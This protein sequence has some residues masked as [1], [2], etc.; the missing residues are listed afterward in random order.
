[1][2]LAQG[3]IN[4]SKTSFSYLVKK[5]NLELRFTLSHHSGCISSNISTGIFIHLNL[6][7]L[8]F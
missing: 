3:K 7:N 4:L 6:Y 8:L 1:M 5:K 2:T